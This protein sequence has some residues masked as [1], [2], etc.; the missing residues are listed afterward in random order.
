MMKGKD[1]NDEYVASVLNGTKEVGHIQLHDLMLKNE[2][3]FKQE[4]Y[5]D[6]FVKIY[7]EFNEQKDFMYNEFKEEN[8]KDTMRLYWNPRI[9]YVCDGDSSMRE[10]R[11]GLG[12]DVGSHFKLPNGM[13]PVEYERYRVCKYAVNPGIDDVKYGSKINAN[14]DIDELNDRILA[15]HV[16]AWRNLHGI[17]QEEALGML[18]EDFKKLNELNSNKLD[19]LN[20]D[21]NSAKDLWHVTSGVVYDFPIEDIQLFVDYKKNGTDNFATKDGK[22]DGNELIGDFRFSWRLSE[23]TLK[24]IELQKLNQNYMTLKK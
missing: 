21:M 14:A 5:W 16:Q 18:Q 6:E 17:S 4:E 20:F 12:V 7:P 24:N 13:S 15:G 8:I 11:E 9:K 3:S 19:K 10:V 2:K 23:Q 22:V 1:R